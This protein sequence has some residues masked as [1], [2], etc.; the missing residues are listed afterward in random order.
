[1]KIIYFIV[2]IILFFSINVFYVNAGYNTASLSLSLSTADIAYTADEADL[3]IVGDITIEAWVKIPTN[4]PDANMSMVSKWTGDTN[5][6]LFY[7]GTAGQI[8]FQFRDGGSI[9]ECDTNIGYVTS[10]DTWYHLAAA[11]DVSVP[12]VAF[13][14]DG[15]STAKASGCELTAAT[16]IGNG[17]TLLRISSYDGS[18]Y[19]FD[20]LIDDVRLWDDI[21]SGAEIAANYDTQL[22]GNEANLKAYWMFNSS[23]EDKGEVTDPAG[24]AANDLTLVNNADYDTTD[25]P[26]DPAPPAALPKPIK[27][28]IINYDT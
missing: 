7:L 3:D 11:V 16:A 2:S 12:S 8:K 4:T 24:S 15:N 21:R 10:A 26:F 13:Y 25:V 9:T 28:E 1:M 17:N 20:G 6:Y 19:L 18:A 27:Q 5:S 14:V 23:P 22:N